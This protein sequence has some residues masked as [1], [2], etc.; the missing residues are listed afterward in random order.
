MIRHIG[1]GPCPGICSMFMSSSIVL[2]KDRHMFSA[3]TGLEVF[4]DLKIEKLL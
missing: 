4:V 3:N 1:P 2:K